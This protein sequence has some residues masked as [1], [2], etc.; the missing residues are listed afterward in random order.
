MGKIRR[1]ISEYRVKRIH[2]KFFKELISFNGNFKKLNKLS[3]LKLFNINYNKDKSIYYAALVNGRIDLIN[4][5]LNYYHLYYGSTIN[6]G[7]YY[8]K[9]TIK[10]IVDNNQVEKLKVF[11]FNNFSIDSILHNNGV[12]LVE[13]MADNNQIEMFKSLLIPNYINVLKS[14]TSN[15]YHTLVKANNLDMVIALSNYFNIYGHR[16]N[17]YGHD[18][19]M[20]SIRHF[21]N[22]NIFKYFS[23]NKMIDQY[24][25]NV[26]LNSCLVN[27]DTDFLK[28]ILPIIDKNYKKSNLLYFYFLKKSIE[29]YK[30]EYI[31][32]IVNKLNI[33]HINKWLEKEIIHKDNIN[34]IKKL[35]NDRLESIIINDKIKNNDNKIFINILLT[36][37][38]LSNLIRNNLIKYIKPNYKPKKIN[39]T[40]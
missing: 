33:N 26:I 10:Y 13:I 31:K 19:L 32:I 35:L 11:I 15:F 2:D 4:F 1:K 16:N 29:D 23:D 5:I 14:T 40:V 8:Y 24:N 37:S 27:N 36:N 12:N 7:S 22:V 25:Y 3:K 17:R 34:R 18:H 38:F 6:R 9:K 30:P 20:S 39:R 21:K 28:K